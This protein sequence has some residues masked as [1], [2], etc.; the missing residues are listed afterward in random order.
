MKLKIIFR[1]KFNKDLTSLKIRLN[2]YKK[3]GELKKKKILIIR[4]SYLLSLVYCI[5]LLFY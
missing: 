3:L 2:N 4:I 1:I 5:V